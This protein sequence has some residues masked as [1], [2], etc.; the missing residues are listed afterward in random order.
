MKKLTA[1]ALAAIATSVFADNKATFPYDVDMTP[2][3][4]TNETVEVSDE[5]VA[6]PGTAT[7]ANDTVAELNMSGVTFT[8]IDAAEWDAFV[9]DY[10]GS[11]AMLAIKNTDGDYAWCGYSGS[12]WVTLTGVDVDLET[13]YDVQISFDRTVGSKKIRYAVKAKDASGYTVL[14]SGDDEWI[15]QGGTQTVLSTVMLKG[16]GSI[17]SG[18]LKS[19]A[20]GAYANIT[21]VE[22]VYSF[23]YSNVVVNVGVGNVVYGDEIKI[24]LLDN[25]AMKSKSVSLME[26]VSDY[27]FDFSNLQPGKTYDCVIEVVKNDAPAYTNAGSS[28]VTLAA[29]ADWFGFDGTQLLKAQGENVTI[30]KGKLGPADEEQPAVV[31][32]NSPSSANSKSTVEIVVDYSDAFAETTQY[33]DAQSALALTE[34]GWKCLIYD[35]EEGALWV[36]ITNVNVSTAKDEYATRAEFDY[37]DADA[38]SPGKVRFSV[39]QGDV[40]HVMHIVGDADYCW[41]DLVGS[42][43]RLAGTSF[44]GG[45]TVSA[46]AATYSSLEGIEPTVSGTTLTLAGSTDVKLANVAVGTYDITQPSGRKYSMKWTDSA[47]KHATID[48][49]GKLVVSSGVAANGIDSYDSYALGLDPENASSKPVLDSEQNSDDDSMDLKVANVNPKEDV[50][51]VDMSVVEMASPDGAAVKEY[52]FNSYGTATIPLPTGVK[53]YKVKISI[54]TK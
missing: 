38:D 52:D 1:F 9:A 51:E 24:T 20:R 21:G 27:S 26:G 29:T 16:T 36:A 10:A 19:G 14:K 23:D 48:S 18:V 28:A 5:T 44:V 41:F 15:A 8:A 39:K 45:G 13:T 25:G 43:N 54:K 22:Q 7:A 35:V 49:N 33:D 46:I 47:D 12:G 6:L 4:A 37:T 2:R 50:A 32:P 11:A 34:N 31:T 30:D 42:S 40:W 3:I 53:Y 17:G